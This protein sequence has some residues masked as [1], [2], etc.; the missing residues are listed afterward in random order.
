MLTTRRAVAGLAPALNDAN[1]SLIGDPRR[2]SYTVSFRTNDM[3]E[4]RRVA[5]QLASLGLNARTN[6]RYDDRGEPTLAYV[7]LYDAADQRRLF[8]IL[9]SRLDP[10]RRQRLEDLVLARGPIPDE[11]LERI[12][13][14]SE[15][16][17]WSADQLAKEMNRQGIIAGMRGIRWTVK[18]VRAA[19]DEYERRTADEEAAQRG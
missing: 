9:E 2:G 5:N 19:L 11:L 1:R 10:N 17:D 12:W 18:K 15:R 14:A 16:L 7:V 13:V 3:S 6:L 8:E 4:A